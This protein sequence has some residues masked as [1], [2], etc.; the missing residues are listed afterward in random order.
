[1]APRFLIATRNKDRFLPLARALETLIG[2]D[3]H[4]AASGKYALT[5]AESAAPLLTVIDEGLPDMSGLELSRGLLK[6]NAL[7]NTALVSRLSPEDFHEF[8]EGLGILV[9]LP[10]SSGEKEARDIVSGLKRIFALPSG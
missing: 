1:M 9:Q 6:A 2:A 4:W 5:R 3:I 8:S 7:I 10:E